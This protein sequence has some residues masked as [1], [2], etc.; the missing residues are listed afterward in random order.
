MENIANYMGADHHRC[1]ELFAKAEK[2]AAEHAWEAAQSDFDTFHQAM[3]AHFHMEE[4]FLFPTFEEVSGQSMGP[5][6]VMR[7]EH[8]QMR[9]LFESMAEAVRAHDAETFLG[10]AETLLVLMQQHNMK[11]EQILYPMSD[12]VLGPQ[13]EALLQQMQASRG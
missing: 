5:T 12:Q 1:D 4:A 11:E 8:G 9:E 10:D 7:M 6:Q 3:E 13:R 2:S